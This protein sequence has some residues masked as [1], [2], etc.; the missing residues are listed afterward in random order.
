MSEELNGF[1]YQQHVWDQ[2]HDSHEDSDDHDLGLASVMAKLME[3]TQ[4]KGISMVGPPHKTGTLSYFLNTSEPYI[5]EHLKKCADEVNAQ[6]TGIKQFV[7]MPE[8][9]KVFQIIERPNPNAN[10]NSKLKLLILTKDKWQLEKM[11]NAHFLKKDPIPTDC[12][13]VQKDTTHLSNTKLKKVSGSGVD[14]HDIAAVLQA[15]QIKAQART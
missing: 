4:D 10:N 9:A 6:G 14:P 12:K 3:A 15:L 13:N 8:H 5:R 2:D 11:W 7:Q 1:S